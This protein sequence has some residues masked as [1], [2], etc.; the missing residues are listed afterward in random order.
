MKL[1]FW[2]WVG[3]V[4]LVLGA[5]LYFTRDDKDKKPD[6]PKAPQSPALTTSPA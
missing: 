4:L 3:V 6:P 5:I 2:Q 1:N